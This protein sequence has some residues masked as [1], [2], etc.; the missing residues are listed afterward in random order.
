MPFQFCLE[1]LLRLD[2]DGPLGCTEAVFCPGPSVGVVG[3]DPELGPDLLPAIGGGGCFS[4]CTQCLVHSLAV[5]EVLVF[6][7]VAVGKVAVLEVV[8][9]IVAY[10]SVAFVSDTRISHGGRRYSCTCTQRC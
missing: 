7:L 10:T 5:V 9:A 4:I 6:L 2:I 1:V 3:L 8:V